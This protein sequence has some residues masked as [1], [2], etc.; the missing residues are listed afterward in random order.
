MISDKDRVSCPKKQWH[1]QHDEYNR[2]SISNVYKTK[3]AFIDP[4]CAFLCKLS[5]KG[6]AA[7]YIQMVNSGENEKLVECASGSEWKLTQSGSLQ[8]AALRSKTAWLKLNLQLLPV[9]R[10]QCVMLPI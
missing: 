6:M 5:E 4:M 10:G 2:D 1:L 9:M 3:D 8:H 7:E